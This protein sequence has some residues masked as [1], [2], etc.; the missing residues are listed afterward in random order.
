MDIYSTSIDDTDLSQD[1]YCTN[2]FVIIPSMKLLLFG[3]ND[4]IR[5]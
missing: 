1:T 3:N 4:I 2:S 5:V